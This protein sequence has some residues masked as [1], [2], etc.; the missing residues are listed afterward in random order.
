ML[1]GHQQSPLLLVPTPNQRVT[2]VVAV[3]VAVVADKHPALACTA[4]PM[5]PVPTAAPIAT[6]KPQ[7]TKALP[8]SPTCKAVAPIVVSGCP[9]DELGPQLTLLLEILFLMNSLLL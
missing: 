3:V 1:L 6:T 8:P 9:T 2:L 5:V 7:V 4:G